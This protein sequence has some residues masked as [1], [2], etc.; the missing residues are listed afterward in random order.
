MNNTTLLADSADVKEM[1]ATLDKAMVWFTFI[2]GLPGNILIF[3]TMLTLPSSVSTFHFCLLSIMDLLAL[4]L[5]LFLRLLDWYEVVNTTKGVNI[6]WRT[7]FNFVYYTSIYANWVLV[8]IA[9]ERLIATRYPAQISTYLTLPRAKANAVLTVI[10]IYCFSAIVTIK[11]TYFGIAWAVVFTTFYT[12]F[13]LMLIL[14]IILLLLNTFRE[15]RKMK[16]KLMKLHEH[17]HKG[18]KTMSKSL[19]GLSRHSAPVGHNKYDPILYLS[20]GQGAGHTMSKS[21][22]ELSKQGMGP[23]HKV[24][25]MSASAHGAAYSPSFC[26]TSSTR[27][28]A[29]STVT[30]EPEEPAEVMAQKAKEKAQRESSYT[31]MLLSTSLLFLL[32]TVPYT[33]IQFIY[34][35]YEKDFIEEYDES[36]AKMY[37][38][39]MIA[40]GLMY[41]Q[42]SLKFYVFFLCSSFFRR[43]FLQGITRLAK[44]TEAS[45][46]TSSNHKQSADESDQKK[47]FL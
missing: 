11:M 25:V 2:A 36:Q 13:P 3:L 1:A 31:V 22:G 7:F 12:G 41:V 40:S 16:E 46:S 45:A 27:K 15:N 19:S 47:A 24:D 39:I 21:M 42:H 23:H 33:V 4:L 6:W 5:Q 35:S 30:Q 34:V 37:L 43:H 17:E 32:M 14:I 8:Y 9:V 18:D 28:I 29:G 38:L 20:D 26:Y 10:L 44:K